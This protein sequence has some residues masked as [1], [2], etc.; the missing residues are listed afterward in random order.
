MD[1]DR[2]GDLDVLYTSG[3]T[4]D[5]PFLKPYHSVRWIENGGSSW[6]DQQ[7][8][9]LPGVVRALAADFDGDGDLDVAA[10]CFCP[11]H[12]L[13]G[14]EGTA[15]LAS[16]VWLEQQD[17]SFV[18]HVIERGNSV[19]ATLA[20]ADVDHDGALDIIAGNFG[21]SPIST[22]PPITVWRN[23]LGR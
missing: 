20:L 13:A 10:C 9:R 7:L 5:S 2:D 14:Q 17:R 6:R 22:L 8:A 18:M 4:F 23:A 15:G 12:V 3:D 11:P 16:L 1:L 19:H 21:P